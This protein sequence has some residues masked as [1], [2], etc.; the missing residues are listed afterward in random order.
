MPKNHRQRLRQ[1]TREAQGRYDRARDDLGHR[2]GGGPRPGDLFAFAE[3]A[4]HS[5]LWLVLEAVLD[6]PS[7]ESF[8]LL[9]ADLHPAVGS[10]DMATPAESA[11]GSLSLRC[12]FEIWLET[13]AFEAA[14]HSGTLEPE[15]LE[16]ARRKRAEIAAGTILGSSLERETDADPEYQDWLEEG[17]A[18]A[19]AVLLAGQ[20]RRRDEGGG[21]TAEKIHSNGI[22]GVT[23]RVLMEA[24]DPFQV[25]AWAEREQVDPGLLQLLRHVHRVCGQPHLGLAA[26]IDP[27]EVAQ[28]GWAVVFD[29]EESVAMRDA[30]QPLVEHR[31]KGIGAAK[32]RILDYHAGEEWREWLS[33]HGVAAGQVEPAKVPYYLLLVGPPTKIP[34]AFELPLGIEYAVGR[35]SFEKPEDLRKYVESVID[36]ETRRGAS[37]SKTAVFFAPRHPFDPTTQRLADLLVRP[38]MEGAKRGFAIRRLWGKDATRENLSEIFHRPGSSKPPALLFAAAHGLVWPPGHSRQRREQGALLCQEWPALGRMDPERHCFGAAD[39][40]DEAGVQG[41]IAFLYT[42]Y[43]AGTPEYESLPLDG[44]PRRLAERPFVGGLPRRFL[45]HPRGGALAVIGLAE[46]AWAASTAALAEQAWLPSFGDL[47]DGLL[48][49]RPV[50]HAVKELKQRYATLALRLVELKQKKARGAVSTESEVAAVWSGQNDLRS[51]VIVGDP[52]VRLRL[53]VMD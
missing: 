16:Q 53:E 5:V 24:V 14:K 42:S 17:P 45:A 48:S 9:A 35:L 30:L 31:R 4:E 36:C 25:A 34:Y 21:S 19:Q 8:L 47:L 29:G 1:E 26:G 20:R 27:A 51:V 12:A 6:A 28:A 2:K 11:C 46:R 23:G 15:V 43:S 44:E 39:L 18:R 7:S 38:L 3:T 50:G 49:G 22:D 37:Q 13:A 10:T 33:R 32:T 52:A 40:S 41:T